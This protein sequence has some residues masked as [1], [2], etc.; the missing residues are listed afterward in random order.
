MVLEQIQADIKESMKTGDQVKVSTLRF[1]LAQIQNRQIALK[2]SSNEPISEEEVVQVLQKQ[3][4]ERRESIEAYRK[5][6]RDDLQGKEEH[7]LEILNKYLPQQ[8]GEE[9]LVKIVQET[10]AESGAAGL[11]DFGKVMKAVMEKVRGKADGKV[12][13][14]V[15]KKLLTG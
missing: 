10:V 12:V 8:I 11:S 9:E 15:V 3:A 4:K 13:A 1:L 7:E 2:A 6:G 14:I 5:A